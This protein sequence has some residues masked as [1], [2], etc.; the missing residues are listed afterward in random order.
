MNIF[1][2]ELIR[3]PHIYF[4]TRPTALLLSLHCLLWCKLLSYKLFKTPA[5]ENYFLCPDKHFLTAGL[6]NSSYYFCV[7][8]YK[9]CRWS[10]LVIFLH[11][12]SFRFVCCCFVFFFKKSLDWL[13]FCSHPGWL[14]LRTIM[15]QVK[16]SMSPNVV[17]VLRGDTCLF[18]FWQDTSLFHGAVCIW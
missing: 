3:A 10:S 17:F 11:Q 6:L 5:T 4:G 1:S 8:C 7:L 16:S 12:S 9:Q 15:N 18:A 13:F 2:T 14:K